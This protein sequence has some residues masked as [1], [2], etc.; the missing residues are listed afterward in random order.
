MVTQVRYPGNIIQKDDGVK[1]KHLDNLKIDDWESLA[2]CNLKEQEKPSSFILKDFNF[3]IPPNSRILSISVEHDFKRDKS[4]NP[5]KMEPPAFKINFKNHKLEKESYVPPAV[6]PVERASIF[7]LT[8]LNIASDEI[9]NGFEIEVDFNKNDSSNEGILF[10]DFIRVKITY[11]IPTYVIS[12]GQSNNDFPFYD[13]PIEKCLDDE[14]RYTLYFRNNNGISHE[15]QAIKINY[16]EGLKIEKVYFHSSG[17]NTVSDE[18][19]V[20][21]FDDEFDME[22]SIWYP[23]LR[24]KGLSQLRLVFKCVEE[25]KQFINSY[26]KEVGYT[27][28][29]YVDVATKDSEISIHPFEEAIGK[30]NV[31]LDDDEK[32]QLLNRETAIEIDNVSMEFDMPQE[33]I[34]NLKEYC[35]KWLKRDIKPKEHLEALKNISFEI[36]KGERVG[37]IGY[38]GAGKSTLLKIL[39]GVLKPTKGEINIEGKVAPLLELGAGFDHNYSGRENVFL[40]GAILGYSKEFLES[41][42]DEIVE[43]SELGEFMEVPIKNYSSGM[44]AKLGFAVAT[45]VD[46]EILILDEILSVGDV[47]FQ[48]KSSNKLKSMM[49]SGTTVLLVSHST[50]KIRELCHRAIWLEKGEIVMDGEVDKV[51]DAYVEAAKKASSDE[52][53]DLELV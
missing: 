46:P 48:K 33:K 41:K 11:E 14:V 36:K 4:P 34:D 49:G 37:I 7:T 18:D 5:I 30:W 29:L 19:E 44:I 32:F 20:V 12:C 23:G 53:K 1:W 40:N 43:F 42:Y 31:E 38:N 15:K 9:N 6:N 25:G 28:N 52:V 51:C 35:I 24:S 3:N 47:R 26:N 22:N 13:N 8:D 21:K 50:A 17:S 2:C 27:P 39:A 45:L 10:F 16:S